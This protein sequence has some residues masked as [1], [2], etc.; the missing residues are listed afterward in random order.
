MPRKAKAAPADQAQP[1]KSEQVRQALKAL[2]DLMPKALAEL[3]QGQG[4]DVSAA[5]V[6]QIKTKMAGKKKRNG[7]RARAV[8]A[9]QA[10]QRS[11][12]AAEAAAP[13]LPKDAVSLALLQKAKKLAAQFGSVKEAKAAIDAL[14]QLMD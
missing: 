13:A 10:A 12:P 11:A 9:Q 2:P 8:A 7:E 5:F 1:N 3:L 6:S 4:L 14:S